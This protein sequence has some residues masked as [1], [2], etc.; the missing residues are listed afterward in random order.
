MTSRSD[1][2]PLP[3]PTLSPFALA[4]PGTFL[5][6][7]FFT[8]AVW[9]VPALRVPLVHSLINHFRQMNFRIPETHT[10]TRVFPHRSTHG[11]KTRVWRSRV[12]IL[13]T[14]RRGGTTLSGWVAA[15]RLYLSI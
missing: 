15:L 3:K 1:C 2:E 13:R 14:K 9:C 6:V 12:V 4:R 10:P 7:G 5:R 8:A 11:H